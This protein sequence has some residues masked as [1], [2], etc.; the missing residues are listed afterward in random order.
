MLKVYNTMTGRKEEFLPLKRGKVGMYVCGVT[1][2]DECHLGHART[3]VAFDAIRRYLEYKGLE[4]NYVQNFTD[5][6]DKII[7]KAREESRKG[8][9]DLPILIKGIVKKYTGEYFACMDKLNVKKATCY[10]KATECIPEMIEIIK[11]LIEKGY[12]YE[13]DGN[14]HFSVKSFNEYGK[15][16]RRN[17]DECSHKTRV[18][19]EE[20]KRNPMDFALWK[21]RKEEPL[22]D[23]PWGKGRPG[24][25]IECSAMS[26][27]Y[28]G[29]SFDIHAG[30][31]DLIFPHHENEIAQSEGYSNKNL[32]RY[33]LHTGFV[34]LRQE[35]MSKSSGNF[36]TVREVLDKYPPVAVR[37]FLLSTHYRKLIEVSE[38]H[39]E[40]AKRAT[41]RIAACLSN[42][43]K[44]GMGLSRSMQ[45]TSNRIAIESAMD[46]DFN[47]PV[48]MGIIFKLVSNV[49]VLTKN[50]DFVRAAVLAADIE[51]FCNVLGLKFRADEEIEEEL[52][53]LIREREQFRQRKLWEE[54]DVLRQ[55][56]L[57][58]GITLEDTP[59]G[60]QWRRL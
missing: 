30:G 34:T 4:V 10:P 15:L 40:A 56:L 51:S 14:V 57:S 33:W 49:N 29:E 53:S 32:A 11:R 21:K 22:W 58:K 25:H 41:E 31:E 28:L 47:I 45:P 24:W 59:R 54:A 42:V 12:G 1:V 36:F 60:T 20:Q 26:M 16:S 19:L 55:T 8:G 50:E 23:S 7:N 18:A 35:K 27:K 48:A 38:E 37:F 17:L 6:D 2:Y 9:A 46:D 44:K 13:V 3:Y 52:L 39:L 5:V 43:K